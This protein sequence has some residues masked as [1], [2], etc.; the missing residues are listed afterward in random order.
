[1]AQLRAYRKEE[2]QNSQKNASLYLLKGKKMHVSAI[3]RHQHNLRQ[4]TI[5]IKISV[6]FQHQKAE[7]YLHDEKHLHRKPCQR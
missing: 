2:R 5:T 6:K 4:T 1:M 3:N 7:L